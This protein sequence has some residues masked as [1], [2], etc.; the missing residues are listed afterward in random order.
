MSEDATF[1]RGGGARRMEGG[2]RWRR[3]AAIPRGGGC[4]KT[5]PL[6]ARARG[7][8]KAARARRSIFDGAM[9]SP[10]GTQKN[11]RYGTGSIPAG[12]MQ[13]RRRV[14]ARIAGTRKAA[15]AEGVPP[16]KNLS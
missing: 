5:A 8:R 2:E 7:R 1:P 14:P 10:A 11:R 6:K 12:I 13:T 3:F 9:P 16:E 15:F 4:R